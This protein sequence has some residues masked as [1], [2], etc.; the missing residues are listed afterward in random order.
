MSF[1]ADATG[2]RC[3]RCARTWV[4]HAGSSCYPV[5]DP[6]IDAFD[7][8][9]PDLLV[10]AGAPDA[11][12]GSSPT[13]PGHVVNERDGSLAET[14]DASAVD[15]RDVSRV[16]ALQTGR[17]CAWCTNPIAAVSPSGRRTRAD[18]ET[19]GVICRK[20]RNRFL[21]AVRAGAAVQAR[22]RPADASRLAGAPG[23]FAYADPPYPGCAHYYDERQE[24]DHAEL[25]QR[26]TSNYPDGWALSTSSTALREVLA[27]CPAETRVCIWRRRVRVTAGK[28]ALSAWEPLLVVAGREH[29]TM[30]AQQLLDDVQTDDVVLDEVLDYRGRYDS[31]NGALVGMKPPEFAVWMFR[32]LGARPGDTLEDLYPGSGAIG[33]AWRLYTSLEASVGRPEPSQLEPPTRP[34]ARP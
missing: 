34:A 27:L 16:D 26:L 10:A 19:C 30:S 32:Q 33:R 18:A 21:R 3:M 28:R 12:R 17:L 6:A 7:A 13:R 1:Y 14:R 20:R 15:E 4:G 11:F 8:P 25:V 29:S 2:E 5:P 31:F 9:R 24:V 22:R 23:R